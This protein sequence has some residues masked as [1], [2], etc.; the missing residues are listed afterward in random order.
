MKTRE[1]PGKP[2]KTQENPGKP[3]KNEKQIFDFEKLRKSSAE[4]VCF[5]NEYY[6]SASHF[7]V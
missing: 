6:P 2:G 7:C 5:R 3:G 1:N 4:N